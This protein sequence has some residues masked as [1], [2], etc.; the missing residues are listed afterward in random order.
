MRKLMLFVLAISRSD[1]WGETSGSAMFAYGLAAGVRHGWLDRAEAR[2]A[3]DRAWLAPML[4]LAG[5]LVAD[6]TK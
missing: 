2:P 4:W 5:E 6:R 3:V 1:S